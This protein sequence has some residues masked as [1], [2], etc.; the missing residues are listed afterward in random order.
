MGLKFQLSKL[1]LHAEALVQVQILKVQD[2]H[3]CLLEDTTA[4]IMDHRTNWT[5]NQYVSLIIRHKFLI[6]VV[7]QHDSDSRKS[8][9]VDGP[10]ALP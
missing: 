6:P 3:L 10:T 5:G 7:I 2:A 8:L 4:E 9:L 1:P